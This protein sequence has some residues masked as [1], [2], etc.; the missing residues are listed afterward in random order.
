M[1][2]M[3]ETMAYVGATPWHGLGRKLATPPATVQEALAAAGLDW[4]VSLVQLQL[5]DGRKVD[6][7]ATVRDRDSAILGTVGAAYRP[8]QNADAFAFF[9]P[10]VASGS[11]TIETAGSLRGGARV[12]MLC[13]IARPDSVIVKQADDRVAKYLMVAHGHDGHLSIMVGET[14]VRVVCQN[15]LSAALNGGTGLLNIRHTSKAGDTLKSVQEAIERADHDFERAAEM[16]R[17][18]AGVRVT[19][20]TVRQY[21]EAVFP[22]PAKAAKLAAAAPANDANP[23]EAL[24]AR[25]FVP[26][27]VSDESSE[28]A[29]GRKGVADNILEIFEKGGRG[30]DL[31]LPGVKGTAWAAYNAVT[32]YLTWD[33]GRSADARLNN[34][35]LGGRA[36]VSARAVTAA[37]DTFLVR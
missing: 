5:P 36:N 11:A 33:R 29:K 35:W 8:M 14:P 22:K 16:F 32:E 31:N 27:I 25:D 1:A 2:H 23:M 20:A 7:F 17:A 21:I 37:A 6:Q 30:G 15:T 13:K 12:W 19:E 24:M 10:F 3:V 28:D 34:L 4:N 9:N 26:R 18:L